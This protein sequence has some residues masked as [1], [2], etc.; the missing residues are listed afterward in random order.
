MRLKIRT[1]GDA[2]HPSETVVE[3]KTTSG[4][5]RLV[6]D[7][8]AVAANSIYIGAPITRRGDKMMVEIPRETMTGVWRVWV[9]R[10]SLLDEP[11][12]RVA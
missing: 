3:V 7:R 11:Q 6:V 5:E 8:R 10:R 1:A 9:D 2:L 12:A 4:S